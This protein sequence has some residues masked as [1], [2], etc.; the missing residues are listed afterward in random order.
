MTRARARAGLL[1]GLSAPLVT[2]GD[3][4]CAVDEDFN[5]AEP[6]GSLGYQVVLCRSRRPHPL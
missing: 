1:A 6:A 2:T 5:H 3:G 4:W